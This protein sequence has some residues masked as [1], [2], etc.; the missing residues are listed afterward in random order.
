MASLVVALFPPSRWAGRPARRPL[1]DAHGGRRARA[2][3]A[4]RARCRGG[5]GGGGA[6]WPAAPASWPAA[7]TTR[8]CRRWAA[9]SAGARDH[10]ALPCRPS[11]GGKVLGRGPASTRDRE[12]SATRSR[13]VARFSARI[14][15]GHDD[16][17]TAT[18]ACRGR[19][20]RVQ[21]GDAAARRPAPQARSTAA[22]T[23]AHDQ[24]ALQAAAR[25]HDAPRAHPGEDDAQVA[26]PQREG[27]KERDHERGHHREGQRH[28]EHR[29]VQAAR[30]T[31]S[32]GAGRGAARR[33][34][35]WRPPPR[36]ARRP[37]P[38]PALRT[39]AAW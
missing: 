26:P 2:A 1:R 38:G 36:R 23:S 19:R 34:R 39:G 13:S 22:A 11:R 21:L 7:S 24:R 29:P 31:H 16:V 37:D 3:A 27:G 5:G 25:A 33:T 32:R 20:D 8:K 17:T 15:L 4:C 35:R 14:G 28:R 12:T 30:S 9:A 18:C 10:A 6:P